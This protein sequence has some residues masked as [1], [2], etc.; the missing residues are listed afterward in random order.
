MNVLEL[1]RVYDRMKDL[2]FNQKPA[3]RNPVRSGDVSG[4]PDMASE[5]QVYYIKACSTWPAGRPA[6]RPCG[7]SSSGRPVS[8]TSGL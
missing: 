3:K 7:R 1:S 2:G 4:G 5:R 6:N 8:M